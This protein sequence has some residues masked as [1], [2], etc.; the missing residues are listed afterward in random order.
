MIAFSSCSEGDLPATFGA[1]EAK[2]NAAELEKQKQAGVQTIEFKGD[3]AKAY[4]DKAYEA[5]WAGI[6]KQ[7]PVHG[8]KL[9]ELFAAAK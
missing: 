1:V 8:P 9:R 5:G 4:L 3:E 7:S 2:E 6:I